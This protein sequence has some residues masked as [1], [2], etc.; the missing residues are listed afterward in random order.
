MDYAVQF[1]EA[2]VQIEQ[3][4]AAGGRSVGTGFLLSTTSASGAPHTLLVTA[5]HVFTSMPAAEAKI[6]YR[7]QSADGVWRY[8]PQPLAIRDAAGSPL[9]TRHPTR[10]VAVLSIQAP[11][12]FARA[13]LPA[14]YLADDELAA[15]SVRPGSEL[16]V[17]GFPRG[18]AANA[19]GFPILRAGRVSS[20]PLTAQTYP[21]F[22]LDFTVFPGNSGGPVFFAPQGGTETPV[23]AGLLTQQVELDN[24]RLDIGI[25]THARYIA[26]TVDLLENPR[27]P[28]TKVAGEPALVGARPASET[29][30]PPSQM[31]TWL[32]AGRDALSR[33]GQ[34][35]SRPWDALWGRASDLF[36]SVSIGVGRRGATVA[37]CEVFDRC[38][39]ETAALDT[40]SPRPASGH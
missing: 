28:V 32:V 10:D 33:L 21:T 36:A 34:V 5:N 8:A 29:I 14:S 6:G 4:L 27:A 17:L 13:A 16:M 35:V 31:E 37:R 9:W 39:I 3:P 12:E 40:A 18:L 15:R 22:L 7:V 20:Y 25:V 2:T 23:I 38:Q 11:P 19:G 1:I 26:E 30:R 24:E